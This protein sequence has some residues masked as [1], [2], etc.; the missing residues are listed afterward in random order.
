MN[1]LAEK[2]FESNRRMWIFQLFHLKSV[3]TSGIL[4]C[5]DERRAC[6]RICVI[7]AGADKVKQ[8]MAEY[9]ANKEQKNHF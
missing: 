3:Y 6:W 4:N 1:S 5:S 7:K 8:E 9:K 2:S